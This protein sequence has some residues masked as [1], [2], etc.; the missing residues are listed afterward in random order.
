MNFQFSS[1]SNYTEQGP[2]HT[3]EEVQRFTGL[4]AKQI[5][6][7]ARLNLVTTTPSTRSPITYLFQDVVTLRNIGK[8]ISRNLPFGSILEQ[9]SD[10][11]EHFGYDI[12]LSSLKI[13]PVGDALVVHDRDEIWHVSSGQSY[14][15]FE[16]KQNVEPA[17]IQQLPVAKVRQRLQESGAALDL[18]MI[19]DCLRGDLLTS[20]DWFNIGIH[21][22]SLKEF[23]YAQKTYRKAIQADASNFDAYLN[24]GRLL[25]LDD[26]LREAKK[27]YEKVLEICPNSELASYN[28]GTI[29]DT[30]DE[31]DLAVKYYKR[32]PNVAMAHHNLGRIY[33]RHGYE[34]KAIYHLVRCRDLER[35]GRLEGD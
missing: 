3:A 14:L 26:K 1:I 7:V 24:L 35:D 28:L 16:P 5:R 6:D 34:V 20:E 32:A 15:D 29:F 21:L 9:L 4:T 12:P 22:E 13:Q 10:I 25:Q 11:R 30:L 33:E 17:E 18:N 8:W 19:E 31:F 23:K 2:W 27:L